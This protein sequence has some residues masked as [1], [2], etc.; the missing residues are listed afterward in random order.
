MGDR[1]SLMSVEQVIIKIIGLKKFYWRRREIRHNNNQKTDTQHNN[2]NATPQYY[3]IQH[4]DTR[5]NNKKVTPSITTF[6][7]MT[8]GVTIK[9]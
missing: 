1:A 7:I 8:L 6:S 2:K 5:H 4:N 9:T 3:Y